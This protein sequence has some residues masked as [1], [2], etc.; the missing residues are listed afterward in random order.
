MSRLSRRPNIF[1]GELQGFGRLGEVE[2]LADVIEQWLIEQL[3]ELANLQAHRG[4]GQGHFL[5]RAAIGA[6]I[7]HRAEHLKLAKGYA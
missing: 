2:L 1:A 7:A 3:F 4:L 6:V 5:G